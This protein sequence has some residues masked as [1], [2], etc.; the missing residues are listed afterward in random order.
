MIRY[1]KP[2]KIVE[3][4]CGESTKFAQFAIQQNQQ[5]T[6]NKTEHICIEPFEKLSFEELPLSIIRKRVEHL[7]LS[8]LEGCLKRIFYLWIHHM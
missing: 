1:F 3:I 2:T 7:D 4:G 6:A 5:E 8:I